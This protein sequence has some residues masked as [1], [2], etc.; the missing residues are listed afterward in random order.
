MSDIETALSFVCM[1]VVCG[2]VHFLAALASKS[3]IDLV[4]AYVAGATSSII[5]VVVV[6]EHMFQGVHTPMTFVISAMIGSALAL[7]TTP[8]WAHIG[9]TN[10]LSD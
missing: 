6:S 8:L 3:N 2:G 1:I 7:V 5:T 9:Q 4:A 10:P